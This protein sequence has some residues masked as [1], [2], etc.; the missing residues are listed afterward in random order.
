[1]NQARRMRRSSASPSSSDCVRAATTARHARPDEIRR[2]RGSGST[3]MP[4]RRRKFSQLW[5]RRSGVYPDRCEREVSSD[6]PII[7][8]RHRRCCP[9]R[10][11]SVRNNGSAEYA[12]GQLGSVKWMTSTA[13]GSL[14]RRILPF[15]PHS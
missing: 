7:T 6:S 15:F 11:S 12:H 8:V 14:T 3:G 5:T 9:K 10:H 4:K 1:M 2:E 13:S